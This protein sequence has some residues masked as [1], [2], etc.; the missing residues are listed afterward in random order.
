M[1]RENTLEN[2][3]PTITNGEEELRQLREENERLRK[4]NDELRFE[5]DSYYRS[6][7][8]W[9]KQKFESEPLPLIPDVEQCLDICVLLEELGVKPKER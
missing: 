3:P 7:V 4:E 5:R 6:L 2:G 9:A 8:A 1:N